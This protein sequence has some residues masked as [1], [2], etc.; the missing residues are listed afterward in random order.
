MVIYESSACHKPVTNEEAA[1]TALKM[2]SLVNQI[3]AER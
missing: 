2:I 1:I 3:K